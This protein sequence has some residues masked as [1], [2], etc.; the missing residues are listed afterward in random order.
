MLMRSTVFPFCVILKSILKSLI[1]IYSSKFE[2]LSI[3]L[4]V[5]PLS[6]FCVRNKNQSLDV[7]LP[8]FI[9]VFKYIY[10]IYK[11]CLVYFIFGLI[12]Q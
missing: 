4:I 5:E 1:Y 6:V 2:L 7:V 12:G 8:F 3:L 10:E 11:E 9:F